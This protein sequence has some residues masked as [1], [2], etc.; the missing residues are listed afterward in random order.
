MNTPFELRKNIKKLKEAIE[1]ATAVAKWANKECSDEH[2]QLIDWL[3]ELKVI[4]EDK[5]KSMEKIPE[6]GYC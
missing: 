3:T 2:Y 5:L 1:H 4:K 6:I